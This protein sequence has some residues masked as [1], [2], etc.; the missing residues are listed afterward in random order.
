MAMART[1]AF[2]APE[3]RR[4][5]HSVL[6]PGGT[7][8][9]AAALYACYPARSCLP[10]Q[11]RDAPKNE[12]AREVGGRGTAW[13]EGLNRTAGAGT[14]LKIMGFANLMRGRSLGMSDKTHQPLRQRLI[15]DMTAVTARK[16]GRP[17]PR[18]DLFN[19]IWRSSRSAPGRSTRSIAAPAVFLHGD[20]RTTRP[21]PPF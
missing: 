17:T 7:R 6:E 18:L 16:C 20:A 11:A 13:S 8:R 15:D 1:Q 2:P 21:R 14:C 10:A 19:C 3:T 4:R 9:S 12:T 5:K